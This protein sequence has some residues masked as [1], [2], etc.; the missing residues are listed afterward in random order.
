MQKRRA[1]QLDI[2]GGVKRESHRRAPL[3]HDGG[4]NR[5]VG[6]RATVALDRD[7]SARCAP[8]PAHRDREGRRTELGAE[9]AL[10]VPRHVLRKVVCADA[11][12][13][14]RDDLGLEHCFKRVERAECAA[15]DACE[16]R[17]QCTQRRLRRQ[18]VRRGVRRK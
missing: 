1:A 4:A 17:A 11:L 6:A 7:G 13:D 9:Q 3:L 5:G 15:E 10:V 16:S 2:G 12:A 18:G 8:R 14:R